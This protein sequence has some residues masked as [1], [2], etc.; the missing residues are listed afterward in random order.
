MTEPP[1]PLA[2]AVL[3]DLET[4]F[5]LRGFV[6]G[7]GVRVGFGLRGRD[8]VGLRLRGATSGRSLG[9][10]SRPADDRDQRRPDGDQ[11]EAEGVQRDDRDGQPGLAPA[12]VGR[13]EA[14]DA[15]ERDRTSGVRDERRRPP[16]RQADHRPDH[17]EDERDRRQPDP[18]FPDGRRGPHVARQEEQDAEHPEQDSEDEHP[19]AV[20]FVVGGR[21]RDPVA[22]PLHHHVG[23]RLVA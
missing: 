10:P 20:H 17:Q 7:F 19:V 18:G 14:G 22:V 12:G 3:E 1:A 2:A 4:G 13:Q 9:D 5:A 11:H 21:L 23:T 6:D 16:E 8:S 15:D